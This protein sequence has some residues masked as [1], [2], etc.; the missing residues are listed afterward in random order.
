MGVRHMDKNEQHN[1]IMQLI[2]ELAMKA[3]ALPA[4]ERAAFVNAEID[5]MKHD[6]RR[7]YAADAEMLALSLDFAENMREWG[8][9]S[10]G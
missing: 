8:S 7:A 3:I 4:R 1:R 5:A 10:P 6:F 9:G 2:N